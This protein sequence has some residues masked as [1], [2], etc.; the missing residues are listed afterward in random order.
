[1]T[2][3]YLDFRDILYLCQDPEFPVSSLLRRHLIAERSSYS[4]L[5][6][7]IDDDWSIIPAIKV[8]MQ[9]L[10]TWNV[11]GPSGILPLNEAIV[12]ERADLCRLFIAAGARVNSLVQTE[13]HESS[14]TLFRRRGMDE[15]DHF[16]HYEANFYWAPNDPDFEPLHLAAI[17]NNLDIVD[18]LLEHDANPNALVGSYGSPLHLTKDYRIAQSLISK[19]A[20]INALN[21]AGS[22][23]LFMAI[24]RRREPFARQLLDAGADVNIYNKDKVS[25]LALACKIGYPNFI[26]QL[27]GAGCDVQGLPSNPSLHIAV[28]N[29]NQGIAQFL[30]DRG[31]NVNQQNEYGTTLHVTQCGEMAEILLAYGADVDAQDADGDTPLML[32]V[33]RRNHEMFNVLLTAGADWKSPKIDW[34][35]F[36]YDA[37]YSGKYTTVKLLLT[38]CKIKISKEKYLNPIPCAIEHGHEGIA[39]LLIENDPDLVNQPDDEGITPIS[40]AIQWRPT[41][42]AEL[43]AA[44]A[45]PTDSDLDFDSDTDPGQDSDSDGLDSREDLRAAVAKALKDQDMDTVN[46]LMESWKKTYT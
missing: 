36:I 19:G 27:I 8:F 4:I 34:D 31:A 23:P 30:L 11:P 9:T 18:L 43:L 26:Y 15:I 1:M 7:V 40:A 45:I 42:V 29:R 46:A 38:H 3:D 10:G 33:I 41:L 2:M 28:L 37:V 32:N 25:A 39:R 24:A 13:P 17:V 14:P 44:G 5:Q 20:N 35:D 12:Y 6:E 22:P 21:G 16:I